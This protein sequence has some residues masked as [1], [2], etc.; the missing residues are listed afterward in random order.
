MPQTKYV[1]SPDYRTRYGSTPSRCACPAR[2]FNPSQPCKHMAL[3]AELSAAAE[4][5]I[6]GNDPVMLLI[7]AAWAEGD[8]AFYMRKFARDAASSLGLTVGQ[9]NRA[10]EAAR[11]A[12]S[13]G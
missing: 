8:S 7:S 1:P 11:L 3:E 12:A 4:S 2:K 13:N 10:V 6:N 5:G 9:I